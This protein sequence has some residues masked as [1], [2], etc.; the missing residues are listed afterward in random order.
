MPEVDVSNDGIDIETSKG[1]LAR[2][3]FEGEVT[4]VASLPGAGKVVIIRHGEYLSVYANLNDVYVKTGDKLKTKQNIG[5]IRYDD[6]E[7][8]TALQLQIWKGQTKL[9]PEAWLYRNN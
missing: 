4:G 5:T 9:D 2:A 8:K 3:V 1:T 6:G 7:A